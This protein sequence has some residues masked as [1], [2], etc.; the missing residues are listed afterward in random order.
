VNTDLFDDWHP[1]E[2]GAIKMAD[3]WFAAIQ[4][5]LAGVQGCTN[6]L[7]GEYN[8]QVF[9]HEGKA[10]ITVPQNSP[11]SLQIY[12]ISGNQ[13]RPVIQKDKNV[14]LIEDLVPGIYFMRLRGLEVR[15]VRL[16]VLE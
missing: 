7:F 14:Y 6:P 11:Y 2:S 8:P 4:E 1:N 13:L 5:L 9:I 10:R 12:N 3:K 15:V 16:T